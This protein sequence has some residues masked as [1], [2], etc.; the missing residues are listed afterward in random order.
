M[1]N[2]QFSSAATILISSFEGFRSSPYVDPIS[3]NEPISIAYGSTHYCSGIKVTLSDPP[4]TVQQG[5]DMLLCY[6][7]NVVL[8]DFQKH[9]TV[10]LTQNQIDALASLCYNIGDINFD[11]SNLLKQIDQHITDG[12]LKPF[13]LT[14]DHSSGH[15][16]SGLLTRRT[17]EFN[18]FETGSIS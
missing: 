1:N 16:V 7:N 8:P 17:A 3:H 10:D 18:Y 6:L 9:I 14:W 15:I 13:W 12:T 4:V 2:I 5:L 11:K